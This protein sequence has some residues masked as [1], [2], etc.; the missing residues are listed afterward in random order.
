[1]TSSTE[2]KEAG[3]GVITKVA[4]ILRTLG[5]TPTG[6]SLGKIAQEVGLARST[7][8]RLV[9]ALEAEG[10][11][12]SGTSAASIA[13]GPEF[14]RIAALARPSF[15]EKAHPLME[16]LSDELEETVDLSVIKRDRLIFLDQVTG[17]QRLIA[18]SHVGDAFPLHCSSVGKAYLA[19]LSRAEISRLIGTKYERLTPR[20]L[21][22]LSALLPA[23]DVVRETGIGVDEEEHA[24]GICAVGIVLSGVRGGSYGLS[25]P[26]PVSRFRL[27]RARA[28]QLL[29][30]LRTELEDPSLGNA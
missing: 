14:M 18:V 15:V 26:M 6:M 4:A 17:S 1:M 25:V 10:L 2:P 3:V 12:M 19:T 27:K 13:L 7:V 21:P 11:V 30:D 28:E 29:L 24:E 16:R 22:D 5:K 9:F 20:T 8:Q 23:L